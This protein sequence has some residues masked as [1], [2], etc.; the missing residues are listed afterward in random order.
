MHS[1]QTSAI[2]FAPQFIDFLPAVITTIAVLRMSLTLSEQRHESHDPE[3][4]S[5]GMFASA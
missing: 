4:A 1:A 5:N 2:S 3:T